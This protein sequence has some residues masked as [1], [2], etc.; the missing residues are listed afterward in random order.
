MEGKK[1]SIRL[2]QTHNEGFRIQESLLG[3]FLRENMM[4]ARG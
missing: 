3:P 4:M 1:E 2:F